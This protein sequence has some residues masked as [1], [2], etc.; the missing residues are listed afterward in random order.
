MEPF[1]GVIGGL[2]GWIFFT[3]IVGMFR[4]MIS[5]GVSLAIADMLVKASPDV[6]EKIVQWFGDRKAIEGY[7]KSLDDKLIKED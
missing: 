2:I 4:S 5:Y 1:V 6:R 7:L 3:I